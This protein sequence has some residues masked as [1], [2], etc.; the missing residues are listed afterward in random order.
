MT[1]FRK[2]TSFEALTAVTF[3]FEV[4]CAVMPCSVVVGY[5]PES[6]GSMDV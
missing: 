6:G 2:I 5:Q 3:Q 4:F 1:E